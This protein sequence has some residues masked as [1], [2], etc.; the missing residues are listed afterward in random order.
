MYVRGGQV[1]GVNRLIGTGVHANIFDSYN[2]NFVCTLVKAF[3]IIILL[4]I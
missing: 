3:G 1:A 4:I 2:C